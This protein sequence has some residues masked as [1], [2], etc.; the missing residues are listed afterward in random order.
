[1][2]I[3][4]YFELYLTQNSFCFFFFKEKNTMCVFW[5]ENS[6]MLKF[7][8][9]F[10]FFSQ[11]WICYLLPKTSQWFLS[12]YIW[13]LFLRKKKEKEKYD[14]LI[15]EIK[16]KERHFQNFKTFRRAIEY[17]RKISGSIFCKPSGWAARKY[18]WWELFS[19]SCFGF[20]F[21]WFFFFFLTML[22]SVK[23][24]QLNYI[25]KE[26]LST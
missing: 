19:F 11:H 4:I 8:H 5:N 3:C 21:F 6:W 1:M 26:I 15:F 24:L 14:C 22:W 23:S 2:W 25:K 10:Q 17:Q 16:Q 7:L 13:G 20:L 18:L 12:V 9:G